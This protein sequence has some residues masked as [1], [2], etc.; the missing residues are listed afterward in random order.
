MNRCKI[1]EVRNLADAVGTLCT[2][3]AS[4]RCSDCGT[5]LC[6][7][8]AGTCGLCH[9]VFC[10]SCL[11]FHQEQYSKAASADHGRVRERKRA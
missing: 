10:P 3:E 2:G 7:S 9:E 1:I 8:H 6:E 11:T 5:E 4:Q